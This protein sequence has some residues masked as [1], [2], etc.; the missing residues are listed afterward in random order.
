METL[1]TLL[2]ILAIGTLPIF[3]LR[4]I[5]KRKENGLRISSMDLF[6]R[7]PRYHDGAISYNQDRWGVRSNVTVEN[8]NAPHNPRY[9]RRHAVK[10]HKQTKPW[11]K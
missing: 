11:M 8:P 9:E 3:L 10:K 7:G 6:P 2:L 4:L 5:G 1:L